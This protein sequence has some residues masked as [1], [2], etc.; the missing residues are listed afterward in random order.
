M[1]Y[2]LI[3]GKSIS[4]LKD[5]AELIGFEITKLEENSEFGIVWM[6]RKNA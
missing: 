5:S 2:H 1:E 3:G 6:N 4:D